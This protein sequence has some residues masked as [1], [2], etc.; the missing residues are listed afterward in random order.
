MHEIRYIYKE[1]MKYIK[2]FMYYSNKSD[3][4]KNCF[5]KFF[6][7]NNFLE[8]TQLVCY[9]KEKNHRL[10]DPSVPIAPPTEVQVDL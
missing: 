10:I 7:F 8:I 2:Y 3:L 4:I 5:T 1:I 6:F 9:N